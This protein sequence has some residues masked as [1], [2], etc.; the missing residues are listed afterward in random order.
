MEKKRKSGYRGNEVENWKVTLESLM[1]RRKPE[2]AH[3]EL[4]GLSR[5]EKIIKEGILKFIC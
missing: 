5:E 3:E 1:C 4:F 2:R